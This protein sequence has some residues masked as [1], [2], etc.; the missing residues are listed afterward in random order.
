MTLFGTRI[1]AKMLAEE[2]RAVEMKHGTTTFKQLDQIGCE[3]VRERAS[4]STSQ[5]PEQTELGETLW[6]ETSDLQKRCS[7]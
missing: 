3:V 7:V 2:E 4:T 5:N 1:L 6:V